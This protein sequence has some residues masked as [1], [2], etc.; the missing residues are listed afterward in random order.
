MDIVRMCIDYWETEQSKL[1]VK[2][3]FNPTPKDR[4]IKGFSKIAKSM[5]KL[6]QKGVKFDWGDKQEAAF[7]LLKQKLYS[8]P[9]LALPEGTK[10]FVV[11]LAMRR[12]RDW[13]C[14]LEL[15]SDTTSESITTQ[16]KQNVVA[17]LGQGRSGTEAQKPKN[18]KN[19][20]VGGMLL[21]NSKDPPKV[22]TEKLEPHVDGTLCFN[23]RSCLPCYGDLRTVIMHEETDPM[24]KLARMYLKEVV[25]RHGISVSIICDR[26]PSTE[27]EEQKR[28]RGGRKGVSLEPV[29]GGIKQRMQAARDRQKSYI[30]L[31]RN[32][33]EFQVGDKVML[34]VSP[35]KGVKCYARTNSLSVDGL[36]FDDKLQFVE[37][38]VEIM[39]REVKRLKR[40]RIPIIK[41]RMELPDRSL[42]S[43]GN[44]KINFRKKNSH[45]FT[46]SHRHKCRPT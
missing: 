38:P 7:Q 15:L 9:I 31:K 1:T 12:I 42:S 26:D 5:N 30:D 11:Q 33:M 36:H 21:K 45:L 23:G 39:D 8:A 13:R 43:H 34:K 29:W 3:I 35:L 18:I 28:A 17:E 37:E 6:T 19:E 2:K 40:S 41:V 16:G 22:R 14:W 24:E 27:G 25:M 10:D 4:F 44:A 46:K 20:D 32:P